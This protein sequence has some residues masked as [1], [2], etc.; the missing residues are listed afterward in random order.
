MKTTLTT[1]KSRYVVI[2]PTF[3]VDEEAETLLLKSVSGEF[4]GVPFEI[5]EE[6]LIEAS[7]I[8]TNGWTT[9]FVIKGADSKIDLLLDEVDPKTGYT[10]F[11][12]SDPEM[13]SLGPVVTM[14]KGPGGLEVQVLTTEKMVDADPTSDTSFRTI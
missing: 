4:K 7:K 13:L 5:K 14:S 12:F 10:G 2:D 1:T 6:V 9:V 3:E 8:P 11:F